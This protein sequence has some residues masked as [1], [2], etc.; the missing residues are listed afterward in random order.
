MRREKAGYCQ[1]WLSF[2]WYGVEHYVI[3][4]SK[5][6]HLTPVARWKQRNCYLYA[7]RGIPQRFEENN[8]RS[9][10]L[11]WKRK[12]SGVK[13]LNTFTDINFWWIKGSR[14]LLQRVLT[15]KS[16]L[17]WKE[18][19]TLRFNAFSAQSF[20][21]ERV[22]EMK[23]HSPECWNFDWRFK[24]PS[25]GTDS[26]GFASLLCNCGMDFAVLSNPKVSTLTFSAWTLWSRFGK[27]PKATSLCGSC[28]K[29][30]RKPRCVDMNAESCPQPFTQRIHNRTIG[31]RRKKGNPTLFAVLKLEFFVTR[32]KSFFNII[33]NSCPLWKLLPHD[34]FRKLK[35]FCS[36]VEQH[37]KHRRSSWL[38]CRKLLSCPVWEFRHSVVQ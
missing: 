17:E 10:W 6:C 35:N 20:G 1:H 22:C 31:G 36:K 28:F 9:R 4:R 16:S 33:H 2:R 21:W 11:K 5:G 23:D 13:M 24:T 18:N 38:W 37:G 30:F 8:L 25:F 32:E 12:V 15:N 19:K 26:A 3:S 29:S 7:S 14:S 34:D 27:V